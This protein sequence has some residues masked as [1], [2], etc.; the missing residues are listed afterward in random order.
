MDVDSDRLKLAFSSLL[1]LM[2]VLQKVNKPKHCFNH[3]L[4]LVLTYGIE[5]DNL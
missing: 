2:V 4:D 5:L 3:T 1:E